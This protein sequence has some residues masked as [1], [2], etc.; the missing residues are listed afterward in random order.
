MK[1]KLVIFYSLVLPP[2]LNVSIAHRNKKGN[3]N[4]KDLSMKCVFQQSHKKQK[5][6][7]MQDAWKELRV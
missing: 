3:T 6:L 1:Q 2:S 4:L 5:E 7:I